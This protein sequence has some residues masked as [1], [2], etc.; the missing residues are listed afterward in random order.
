MLRAT[1]RLPRALLHILTVTDR[2]F[3]RGPGGQSRPVEKTGKEL[4]GRSAPPFQLG[5][6]DAS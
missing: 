3:E 2:T 6:E 5:L 1:P 4:L